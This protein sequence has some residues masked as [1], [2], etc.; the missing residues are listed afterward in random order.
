MQ[1]KHEDQ[2]REAMKNIGERY[3]AE[4]RIFCAKC[5]DRRC[6]EA[7]R[8]C[9][10]GAVQICRETVMLSFLMECILKMFPF[11]GI[12]DRIQ[13]DEKKNPTTRRAK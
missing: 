13:H 1:K 7:K 10:F 4:L 6:A 12:K 9:G 3:Q 11:F 8:Q 5:K 2:H